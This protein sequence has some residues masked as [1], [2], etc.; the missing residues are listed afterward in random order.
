METTLTDQELAE[1]KR[2]KTESEWNAICTKIKKV[3][4]GYPSDWYIKILASGVLEEA[5]K[6][7]KGGELTITSMKL[8]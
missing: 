4:N 3:H 8:K 2:T 6:R 5:T 7:F 1:L